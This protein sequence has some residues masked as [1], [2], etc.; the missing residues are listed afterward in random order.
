MLTDVAS[1]DIIVIASVDVM[2]NVDI[3]VKTKFEV[4][5]F[6]GPLLKIV[7]DKVT[8]YKPAIVGFDHYIVFV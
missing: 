4:T 2:H 8:V 1:L 7:P 5:V 3:T 6:V